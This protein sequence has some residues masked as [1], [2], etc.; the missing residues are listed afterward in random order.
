MAVKIRLRRMGARNRPFFRVVVADS[1]SPNSGRIIESIGYYDPMR[2]MGDCVMKLDRLDYWQGNGAIAT[3]NVKAL[4][5]RAIP[6]EKTLKPALAAPEETP[7]A[8]T[9]ETPEAPAEETPEAPA[10]ETPEAPAE[11]GA[12]ETTAKEPGDKPAAE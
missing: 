6:Y 3:G 5:K 1:R 12:D 2:V 7:E 9:E 10:E 8:P 11:E 4:I